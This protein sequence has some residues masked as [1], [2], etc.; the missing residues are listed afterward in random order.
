MISVT[1]SF[2]FTCRKIPV[3]SDC[4]INFSHFYFFFFCNN[5]DVKTPESY[6]LRHVQLSYSHSMTTLVLSINT[7]KQSKLHNIASVYFFLETYKLL[8]VVLKAAL[9]YVRSGAPLVFIPLLQISLV[10]LWSPQ[11]FLWQLTDPPVDGSVHYV[12]TSSAIVFP[13]P[14]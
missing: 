14:M 6:R 3:S 1:F 9:T 10:S 2:H 8:T 11:H 12:R 7:I 4:S 5:F 13:S